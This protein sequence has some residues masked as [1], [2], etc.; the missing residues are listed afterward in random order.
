MFERLST[1]WE[2]MKQSFRVLWMDKQ[3]IVFPAV[4]S[5]ACVLVLASFALPLWNSPY[6]QVVLEEGEAPQD[7][8]AYLILFLFYFVNYFVIVFFN[9]ALV[10]CAVIRLKGGEPTVGDGFRAA[11]AVLPQIAGWALVSATVGVVLRIIESRSEKAGQIVAGLLGM[12]WTVL[13]YFVVP[14]LVV[15]RKGPVEATKRSMAI[16][17]RTWGEALSANLGAGLIF[18]LVGLV[19][20]PALIL[21]VVLGVFGLASGS[22]ALA[23]IG[24]GLFILVLIG[25]SLV[26]STLHTILLA[27]LYVY[28][29]EGRVPGA[30][31]GQV[32][33]G[34]F[35]RT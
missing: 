33:E 17:R 13:T 24:F 15:E 20:L 25:I 21:T 14:V 7:A 32:L 30:F 4:S 27:A 26:S 34:A 1:G 31:D 5:V 10:A 16:L 35:A 12:G 28:A 18:L 9:S 11:A 2:L 22:V 6:A 19:A 8:V 3:L 23:V 29:A